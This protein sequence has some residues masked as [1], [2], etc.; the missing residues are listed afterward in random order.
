V[1]HR[2]NRRGAYKFLVGRRKGNRPLVKPRR[3]WEN[4]INMDLQSVRWGSLDWTD[5][6]QDR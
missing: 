4:N 5:L 1:I 6:A 3:R 2:G